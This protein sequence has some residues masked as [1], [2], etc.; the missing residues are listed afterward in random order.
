[1]SRFDCFL[2]K[3]TRE[4]LH[5]KI[6][7]LF[8]HINRATKYLSIGY[9]VNAV[10]RFSFHK[11]NFSTAQADLFLLASKLWRLDYFSCIERKLGNAAGFGAVMNE[12]RFREKE[13][14]N[15]CDFD[16]H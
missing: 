16:V 6:V 8:P 10:R 5:R 7:F 3:N 12:K 1:M 4:F 14:K 11:N 9:M 15:C 2:V 13:K